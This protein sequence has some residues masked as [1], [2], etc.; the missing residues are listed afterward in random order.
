MKVLIIAPHIT[1]NAHPQFLKN[2]TGFGL[3]IHNIAEYVA[4]RI[5]VDVFTQS[6][7]TPQMT[8]DG[9]NIVGRSW[10]SIIGLCGW[11]NIVDF[12]DY[13]SKY[14]VPLKQKI[15][16]FYYFISLGHVEKNAQQYDLIHIHG[17]SP[18]TYGAIK[19]C[20]RNKIP[21]LVTLHGLV[22]FGGEQMAG[23]AMKAFER[24]LLKEAAQKG[25]HISFISSGIRQMTYDYLSVDSLQ[26]FHVV[27]NGCNTKRQKITED[28]REK[29]N[30]SKEDF[31]FS[32]VANVSENKNQMQVVEAF[33]LLT[34]EQR[35]HIKV[36]FVGRDGNTLK[37]YIASCRLSRELIVCGGVSPDEVGNYYAASD[38]TMMTSHS[39]GFGLSIIEGYVYG[40]P[41]LIFEDLPAVYDLYSEKTMLKVPD[42]KDKTLAD[43]MLKMGETSWNNE[44]I[45]EYAQRFSLECMADSYIEL[46]KKVLQ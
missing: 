21:F 16:L 15:R 28:I 46:Y 34:Q 35:S 12:L 10:S 5:D 9:F 44:F 18:L 13:T 38:A 39:E 37:N 17:C 11:H 24:D 25:Y 41:N 6:A 31:V 36:L 43:Y 29:Y 33:K 42:R 7:L 20:T 26:N 3:M 8:I 40:K 45:A 19:I 23:T 22:S 4:K 14:K 27:T 30:C 2:S 1:S 32:F